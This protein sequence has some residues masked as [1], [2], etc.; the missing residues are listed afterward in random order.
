MVLYLILL[1]VICLCGMKFSSFHRDYMS[2][3]E[4]TAIKGVF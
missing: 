3:Q 4:T 2:V 1:L